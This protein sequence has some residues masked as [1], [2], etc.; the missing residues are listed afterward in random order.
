MGTYCYDMCQVGEAVAGAQ[1]VLDT[2][3]TSPVAVDDVVGVGDV[4]Y[5][6]FAVA[7]SIPPSPL[8]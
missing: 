2:L 5:F 6:Q 3:S 7:A 1:T 4:A 8:T